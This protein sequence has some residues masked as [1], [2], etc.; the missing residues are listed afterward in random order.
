MSVRCST[1]SPHKPTL[2]EENLSDQAGKVFLITGASGGIGK[3]LVKILYQRNAKI[4]LAARSYS[5]TQAVIDEIKTAHP[6]STGEMVF[7]KLQLDDLSTIKASAQEF[8][9]RETRLDVLWNNANVM[10]PPQGSTT[11]Q[12]Y[13][14]QLGINNLGHQLFTQLLTPL[15]KMT[16]QV[17]PRDSVRVIWVSSSAADGAPRPAIDF[18]NMDYHIEE[19]IWSK[20]SRSKAGNVIQA[21]EYA[22]RIGGSG[23]ISLSLNPGNFVTNLQQNMPKMQLAMFKLISHP[24]KNGAYTQLFAGLDRSVTSEDNGGWVSPFGKKEEPRKDLID[25]DLGGKYWEWCAA[26][27]KPFS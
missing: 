13:E 2:T 1:L 3:E 25:P 8:L 10:V 12:G 9:S 11:V 22:R 14:L 23:I 27:V 21:S 18:S 15:L 19:G 17:A 24:P 7:L 16:S 20:Y 4:W 26:Q 5:K 6:S